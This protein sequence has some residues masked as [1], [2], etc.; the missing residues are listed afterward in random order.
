MKRGFT[1]L[2][3]MITLGILAIFAVM[4]VTSFQSSSRRQQLQNASARIHQIYV[5][6]K[7]NAQSGKKNCLVCGA[8]N[9]VC[10]KGDLPLLGWEVNLNNSSGTITT[11]G[12]CGTESN[13][14]RFTMD[15]QP[16]NAEKIGAGIVVVPNTSSVMF[17]PSGGGA[18][19]VPI[20]ITISDA[21]GNSRTFTIDN[22]GAISL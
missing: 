14:I 12:V 19:G 8:T 3:F 1:L 4:G 21:Y 11:Q 5:A 6:A 7:T 10:G 16:A 9:G 2:E 20:A 17:R 22:S 13:P 15:Q 18:T